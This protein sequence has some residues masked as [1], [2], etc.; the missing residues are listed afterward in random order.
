MTD[1]TVAG[2]RGSGGIDRDSGMTLR[3]SGLT[4][5]TEC[6]R[7]FANS[8]MM[9]SDPQ[10]LFR[11]ASSLAAARSIRQHPSACVSIRQHASAYG[12]IR[13]RTPAYVSIR[14][15]TSACVS[16][17]QHASASV[18]HSSAYV[19][20][21]Q[22]TSAYGIPALL[23]CPARRTSPR[24]PSGRNSKPSNRSVISA[25][26]GC[27]AAACRLLRQDLYFC[28]SKAS[29]PRTSRLQS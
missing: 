5:L 6:A 29:K 20:I 11:A 8:Q 16:I 1:L 10:Q 13:Q 23:A 14:Q 12:S 2:A 4:L 28:T 7:S 17:R 3:I 18:S 24:R 25:G 15:H 19:S 9:R 21:R 26:G 27:R 22:H